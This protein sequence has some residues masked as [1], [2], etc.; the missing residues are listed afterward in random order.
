MGP[1]A[2]LEAVQKMKA[3]MSILVELRREN[4]GI[5]KIP[6]RNNLTRLRQGQ[7]LPYGLAWLFFGVQ[8]SQT[9]YHDLVAVGNAQRFLVVSC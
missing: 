1:P 4:L 2:K 8:R 5:K 6:F 7:P 9:M 3:K